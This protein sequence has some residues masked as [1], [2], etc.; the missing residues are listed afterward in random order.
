MLDVALVIF[1]C[2]GVLIDSELLSAQVLLEE[3]ANIGVKIDLRYFFENCLG[4]NFAAVAERIARDTGQAID[5]EFERRYWKRLLER[6]ESELR[7]VA[8]AREVLAR[9]HI[10][11]CVATGSNTERATRSLD[12]AGF[13]G[14]VDGRLVSS[15]MVGR[16]KPSPDLFLLAA[17]RHGV[18][19]PRCLVIEDSDMG[20]QAAR[21]AGMPV[22]RFTGGSHF[23]AAHRWMADRS[24]A[25]KEFDDMAEFFRLLNS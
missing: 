20:V 3:L 16:G 19:A 1:D 2:D 21:A 24:P 15:S 22:W 5:A 25:D 13:S 4:R 7:P 9:L 14:L 10:P 12:L 11:F 18:S 23:R 6:F 17:R 8:G